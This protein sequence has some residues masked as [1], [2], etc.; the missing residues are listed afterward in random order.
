MEKTSIFLRLPRTE[1]DLFKKNKGAFSVQFR[2]SSW[3]KEFSSNKK[4]LVLFLKKNKLTRTEQ[5]F[6]QNSSK[7]IEKKNIKDAIIILERD[8]WILF[9]DICLSYNVS[10]SIVLRKMISS[11]IDT[12]SLV[13]VKFKI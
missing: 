7:G 8:S 4:T 5:D 3:V 9:K 13:T 1:W 11:Y 12:G 10:P 2:I 6:Y